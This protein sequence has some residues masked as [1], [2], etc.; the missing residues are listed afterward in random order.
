MDALWV[1]LLSDPLG[2][3]KLALL[4]VCMVGIY[5]LS[6]QLAW[7]FKWASA[8]GGPLAIAGR[9]WFGQWAVQVLRLFYYVG[10]PLIVL[11]RGALHREMGIATTYV[12]RWDASLP[13]L[14]L[15]LGEAEHVLHL[16]TGVVLGC[17]V[18]GVLLIVWIWYTRVA[19]ARVGSQETRIVPDV[20]W[21][22]ALQEAL[23][24]QL[25][26]ALYRGTA[27][28]L[29]ADRLQAAFVSLALVTVSWIL[30]PQRRRDLFGPGGYLVV[31]DW[32]FALFTA[33]LSLTVQALWFLVLMHTLWIWFSGRVMAHLTRSS[34][35]QAVSRSGRS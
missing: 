20:T 15:G 12:G 33:F 32:L 31:Q 2:Q 25:L 29:I 14:L 19:L 23:Y 8:D 28:Q 24:L 11:W 6:A 17:L 22:A 4:V 1:W 5:V 7:R 34:L 27:A 30:N 9:S 26:W 13:L 16:G 35:H 10:V 3:E 21:W 18:L